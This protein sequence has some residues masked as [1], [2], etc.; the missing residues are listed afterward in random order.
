MWT[1][2]VG[3]IRLAL[4]PPVNHW[5]HVTLDVTPR[6][7]TTRAMPDGAGSFEMAFDFV[8]HR[9]RDRDERRRGRDRSELAPRS[10][11]RISTRADG[12]A[13]DAGHP[14]SA[15]GRCRSRFRIPSAS[16]TTRGTRSYDAAP[17]TRFWRV[18]LADRQR[19]DGVPLAASSASAARST[20]SGAAS[21]SR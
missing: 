2:V 17:A 7:L 13:G 8:E 20:S 11:S 3:K 21:T 14:R 19:A 4:A 10:A 16:T 15:S 12:A 18:L 6:G 9:L 1:Q 5:W